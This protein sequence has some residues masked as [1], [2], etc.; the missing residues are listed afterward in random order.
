ML[1][2]RER[3]ARR[4]SLVRRFLVTWLGD[5]DT[6][7]E[8]PLCGAG[9]FACQKM[10]LKWLADP[11]SIA[12]EPIRCWSG[13]EKIASLAGETACPTARPTTWSQDAIPKTVKHPAFASLRR[14]GQ[15]RSVGANLEA[16]YQQALDYQNGAA[17]GGP[18]YVKMFR[19]RPNERSLKQAGA[20]L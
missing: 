13:P 1:A 17:K 3:A 7:R 14:R 8:D 10:R 11:G 19:I 18:Y 15:A 5:A 2:R 16:V 6:L 12:R 4:R 9:G 20:R